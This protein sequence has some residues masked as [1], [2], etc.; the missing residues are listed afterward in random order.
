MY[1]E[2]QLKALKEAYAS[3]ATTVRLSSGDQI[4][5]RS[6][7]EMKEIIRTME[8]SLATNKPRRRM[9]YTMRVNKGL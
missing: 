3:G 4:S 8:V 5:Y 2:A 9:G 1:S 6:L 7:Q